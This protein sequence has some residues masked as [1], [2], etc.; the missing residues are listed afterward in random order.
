[1]P[2]ALSGRALPSST[3]C[4]G[5]DVD[6]APRHGRQGWRVPLVVE[7]QAHR[8]EEGRTPL[9]ADCVIEGEAREAMRR[10]V[11]YLNFHGSILRPAHTGFEAR[12][13][14]RL[15]LP[16]DLRR[17]PYFSRQ[18][19]QHGYVPP[20]RHSMDGEAVRTFPHRW[21]API[22]GDW[23]LPDAHLMDTGPLQ[24][25]VDEARRLAATSLL[26][27]REGWHVSTDLPEWHLQDTAGRYVLVLG[28]T[29]WCSAGNV[30]AIDRLEDALAHGR[31][32]LGY[33]RQ[34]VGE[35][36]AFEPSLRPEAMADPRRLADRL[37]RFL[38]GHLRSR[39]PDMG[40]DDVERWHDAANASSLMAVQGD[41]GARRVLAACETLFERYIWSKSRRHESGWRPER[42][43][44]RAELEAVPADFPAPGAP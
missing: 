25:A 3:V 26:H 12:E 29:G 18:E 42:Q 32:L 13:R 39:I 9:V 6:L 15:D 41:A 14:K 7:A 5:I 16:E 28:H 30:F 43:R 31:Q 24:A 2:E 27:R 20:L 11:R 22:R 17:N 38:V 37:A 44:L 35:V 33:D 10:R 4:I 1:M 36:R 19:V 34:V 21:L 40:R 23:H 8:D